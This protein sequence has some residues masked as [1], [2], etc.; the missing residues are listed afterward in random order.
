MP[1]LC[2]SLVKYLIPLMAAA[3]TLTIGVDA[4]A[5]TA[6]APFSVVPATSPLTLQQNAGGTD[7]I[8]VTKTAGFSGSVALTVSGAPAGVGTAFAGNVLIVYPPLTT[9][10][11]SYPLTITGTSGTTTVTNNLC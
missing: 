6:V 8:N 2:P 5:V 9:P 11:G 3:L 4:R 7:T 10:V 1:N